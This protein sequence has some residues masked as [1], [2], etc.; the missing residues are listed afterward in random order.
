MDSVDEQNRALRN[1][2]EKEDNKKYIHK[3]FKGKN[4]SIERG[5]IVTILCHTNAALGVMQDPEYLRFQVG[6]ALDE[7]GIEEEIDYT[8][9]VERLRK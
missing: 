7:L 8:L 6:Q 9:K 5:F 1:A 4:K 2:E 3:K